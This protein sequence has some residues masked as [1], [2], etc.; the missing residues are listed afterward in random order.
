MNSSEQFLNQSPERRAALLKR[1]V[2][3]IEE[4]SQVIK[5]PFA[6]IAYGSGVYGYNPKE[7]G[8]LDDLDLLAISKRDHDLLTVLGDIRKLGINL[9]DDLT[10]LSLSQK[11]KSGEIDFFR[12]KGTYKGITISIHFFAKDS[13]EGKQS[14]MR[15]FSPIYGGLTEIQTQNKLEK[16]DSRLE[17]GFDG[18]KHIIRYAFTDVHNGFDS[19]RYGSAIS[20]RKLPSG[21]K[22]VPT[23]GVQAEKILDGKLIYEPLDGENKP[24]INAG[25]ILEKYWRTFIRSALYYRPEATDDE[26]IGLLARSPRFS[27]DFVNNLKAKIQSERERLRSQLKNSDD[28]IGA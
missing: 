10:L 13:L 26:I 4:A 8:K 24:I 3:Q 5:P 16:Q 23:V 1:A 6:L 28:S 19:T 14:P 27:Q 22:I 11:F 18:L 7:I 15:A 20:R 17:M 9:N 25:R 21:E 12:I 2:E